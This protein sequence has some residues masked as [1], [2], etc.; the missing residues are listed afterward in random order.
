MP[1]LAPK[2][3]SLLYLT[4]LDNTLYT[5]NCC[6]YQPQYG[7]EVLA[8]V[9]LSPAGVLIEQTAAPASLIALPNNILHTFGC[10][11]SAETPVCAIAAKT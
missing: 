4:N 2:C 5:T 10:T 3:S 11:R 6:P 9:V 8:D 1:I 7:P